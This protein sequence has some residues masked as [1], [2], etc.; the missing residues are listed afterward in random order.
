MG[1]GGQGRGSLCPSSAG[2]STRTS[3]SVLGC[4]GGSPNFTITTWPWWSWSGRWG[5]AGPPGERGGGGGTGGV[6][7]G[8]PN[9]PS[10]PRR[11]CIPCTEDANRAMRKPPGM[12]CEEQGGDP[13]VRG[14]HPGVGGCP[15]MRGAEPAPL[16]A[17]PEAELLGRPRVPAEFVSLDPQRLGVQIKRQEAVRTPASWG[18]GGGEPRHLGGILAF[19]GNPGSWRGPRGS[20]RPRCLGGAQAFGGGSR[21]LGGTQG[22]R[23]TWE[24]GGDAG[25]WGRPRR[26]AGTPHLGGTPGFMG[27]LGVRGG[28]RVSRGNPGVWGRRQVSGGP[29]SIPHIPPP[30]GTKAGGDVGLR[31][32]PRRSGGDPGVPG[33]DPGLS[34]P[35]R[36]GPP[37][38]R[39]R[40]SR[41]RPTPKWR[42]GRW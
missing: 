32:G 19:G 17:P 21:H 1:G 10:R 18:G 6:P 20:G 27:D 7:R 23:E 16:P 13:G 25:I 12:T 35:P 41:G 4:P 38:L 33:G 22:F 31:G 29:C 3:T 26:L 39:G 9:P 42:W 30:L 8:T 37:A 36:S 34:P 11:V 5:P 40:R 28:T 14:G 15:G 24:S 2:C